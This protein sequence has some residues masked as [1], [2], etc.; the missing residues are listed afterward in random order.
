MS[1]STVALILVI[2]G[3]GAYIL[4][5]SQWG[6]SIYLSLFSKD[7]H[8]I[9]EISLQFMED[10]QFKD[11]DKAASYHS[12][13]DREK[14]DIPRLMRKLFMIKPEL[15]DVMDYSILDS[16]LDSTGT[17]GRVKVKAKVNILN[18]NKIKHP[19]VIL[20]F[21]KKGDQW[22]MEMESSLQSGSV[23]GVRARAGCYIDYPHNASRS[24]DDRSI[25]LATAWRKMGTPPWI[26]TWSRARVIPV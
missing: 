3:V 24:P 21:H 15:I 6:R 10:V 25:W 5:D 13:E 23:R 4:Y 19:E 16:S 8:L 26:S 18:S 11:F 1:K 22:Y 2:L 9:E 17:R 20:Y 14:I 12:P 7:L